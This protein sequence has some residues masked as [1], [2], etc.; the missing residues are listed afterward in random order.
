MTMLYHGSG[1]KQSELMP[2]FHRSGNLVEWDE[3]ESN[4]WLYTTTDR[5][6][7]IGQGFASTV[8]KIYKTHRYIE[9]GLNIQIQIEKGQLPTRA[10]LEAIEIYLYTI[11][12]KPADNWVK[13]NNKHN[14]LDTEYKSDETIHR[15][16]VMR[17][18]IDMKKWLENRTIEVTRA[19]PAYAA[20]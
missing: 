1:F 17:E 3:T 7:A 20:W 4:M 6:V 14:G 18:R 9:D 2:G 15:A 11:E 16:I 8:E 5:E 13:V 19:K 12:M 10:Q